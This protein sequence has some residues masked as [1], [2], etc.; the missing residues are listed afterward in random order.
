MEILKKN[1]LRLFILPVMVCLLISFYIYHKTNLNSIGELQKE[2][3]GYKIFYDSNSNEY[4]Y[5]VFSLENKRIDEVTGITG[6]MSIEALSEN[7]IHVTVSV[8]SDARQEW[9]YD[10]I[11]GRKSEEYFNISAINGSNIVYMEFTDDWETHLVIRDIFNKEILYEE[12][13][14][15][16]SDTAVASTVL[17]N[18]TFLN[19]KS[20]KIEY[21]VGEDRRLVN[22]IIELS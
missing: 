6:N 4:A 18:V 5:V 13:V 17:K 2:G 3:I 11:T 14:R 22:E 19:D 20:I 1:I 8:G 10:R 21:E 7:L 16:F 9:F 15:D 12:I